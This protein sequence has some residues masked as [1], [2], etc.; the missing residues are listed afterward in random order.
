MSY[1]VPLPFFTYARV[2]H[3]EKT[4]DMFDRGVKY[5]L[6][7]LIQTLNFIALSK[8]KNIRE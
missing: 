3:N 5:L 4:N 7:M 8:N 6:S 1:G 2:N